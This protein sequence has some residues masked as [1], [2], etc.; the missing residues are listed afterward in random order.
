MLRLRTMVACLFCLGACL[1]VAEAQIQLFQ[2][3]D[4][5]S[6]DYKIADLTIRYS[7]GRVTDGFRILAGKQQK[8]VPWSEITSLEIGAPVGSGTPNKYVQCSV[9]FSDGTRQT[10]YCIDGIVLGKTRNGDYKKRLD[11]VTALIPRK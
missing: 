11:Q 9:Q 1:S 8:L 5:N 7:D 2:L 10:V 6:R 4:V 3:S